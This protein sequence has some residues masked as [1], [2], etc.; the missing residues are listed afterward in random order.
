MALLD[1]RKFPEPV[2]R[3][4]AS[5]VKKVDREIRKLIDDMAE[6]MYKA[7][8]V[9]LAANQVGKLLRVVVIDIQK[10][11]CEYGLIVLVNPKIVGARGTVTYEEGCLSVPG[12][13]SNVKRCEEVTVQ[14]LDQDE[15]PVEIQASGLLAV[16][17]QHEIDHLEGKLFID[18]MGPISRDIFRR[19]WKKQQREAEA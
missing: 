6:T 16:V 5:A 11:E 18:R 10:P 13:F 17:L 19:K 12:F 15:E 9:G 1:I 4:K 3:Q 2:L 8:G 7:P 14:G